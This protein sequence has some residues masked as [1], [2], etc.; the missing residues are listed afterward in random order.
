MQAT[1]RSTPTLSTPR[2]QTNSWIILLVLLLG[3]FMILL[4]TTIVNVA[5]PQME[6][7]L[8]TPFDHILWILNGYVLVYAVLMITAGR[9]GDMFGPKRLFLI[10]LVLFT[11]SSLA[12]GIS[13]S[14]D[15]LIA[16]RLMQGIGAALLSPQTLNII[17]NIFPPERR[18]A[19]FGL[20][21]AVAGIAATIGPIVGGLLVTNY[22]WQSVFFLNVPIGIVTV[23]AVSLVTPE[24]LAGKKHVI[25]IPGIALITAGLFLLV[26]ALIEGQQ[27]GWGPI[28]TL[29]SFSLGSTHWSIISIYSLLV[30]A[31]VILAGF[32]AV[33]FR[34]S[35]PL[36]PLA[37][38][39]DWNFAWGNLIYGLLAV[40]IFPLFAPLVIF[41]QSGLGFTA[42]HSGLTTVPL[43]LGILVASPITGKLAD[44]GRA[45]YTMMVGFV[46]FIIGVLLLRQSLALSN[47]SWDL[48]IPLAV[49][50]I[51]MGCLFAPLTTVIMTGVGLNQS[52]SASGFLNMLQQTGSAVGIAIVGAIFARQV[53]ADLPH[54]ASRFASQ[55]PIQFRAH[56]RA[57]WHTASQGT[58]Q[59]GAG[60]AG[61]THLT[62]GVP[63]AIAHQIAGLDYAVFSNALLTG[64]RD[65]LLVPPIGIFVALLVVLMLRS[66]RA[67]VAES[68]VEEE[69]EAVPA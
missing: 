52:G 18:G 59:F 16:F 2:I 51:G 44:S 5:I 56:F 67:N 48:T 58:Q 22:G 66:R 26:F 38:L 69:R 54:Q 55:L 20:W 62:P 53:A 30:Y 23:A 50:G 27:Y 25:D 63:A 15:Q 6:R 61:G 9:L 8:K 7:G 36:L 57:V 47:S 33:E 43:S 32:V 35:E 42:I 49:M 12:C 4:D 29:G 41:L 40:S 64:T 68:Q 19:A 31:A 21:G 34:A 60:Q 39:K 10:G 17:S 45:K 65:A 3:F 37:L 46:L 1:I 11:L 13:R 24:V 14:A 28:T